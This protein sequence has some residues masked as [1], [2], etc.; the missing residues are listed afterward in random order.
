MGAIRLLSLTLLA[1]VCASACRDS[2]GGSG[3]GG[4]KLVPSSLAANGCTGPNQVFVPGTPPTAVPLSTASLGPFSQVTAAGDSETLFVTG[5]GATLVQIDVSGAVP[6]ETEILAAGVVD[7][8][9]AG[10]G[11]A[12]PAQLSGLCVLDAGALLAVEHASNTILLVDRSGASPPL[13]FAGLPDETGGFADG[14]ALAIPG[15]G[16]ARFHFGAPTQV[17]ATDPG[18]GLVFVADS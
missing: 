7:A 3:G 9:L 1:A 4:I 14:T 11:I 8:L 16:Q 5:A 2:K 6:V 17:I 13:F 18:L 10:A 12:T 15:A